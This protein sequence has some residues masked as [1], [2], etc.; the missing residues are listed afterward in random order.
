MPGHLL[1]LSS[2]YGP[3]GSLAQEPAS[4]PYPEPQ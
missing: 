2:F 1:Q 3:E 4:R